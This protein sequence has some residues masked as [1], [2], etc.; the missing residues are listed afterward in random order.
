MFGA[1]LAARQPPPGAVD[2][3]F[4]LRGGPYMVANGGNAGLVNAHLAL[5]EQPGLRV[6]RGQSH[7]VDLVRVNRAGFRAAGWPLPADPAAYF[8]F[9][10]PVYAPCSGRV[11][12]A[13]DG[14]ADRSPPA[15]D[16]AHLA[17]NYVLLGCRG[18][19]VLLGHL[20]QGSVLV[21]RG[22]PVAVGDPLAR[23]GN[24]GN[25]DEPHLHI[26][27]Q[28]PG[29]D[30]HPLAGD[31]VPVRFGGEYLVRNSIITNHDNHDRAL[32]RG[33]GARL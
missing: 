8:I 31:P 14:L 25:T 29:T 23:V 13:R 27:A 33:A 26:H 15:R 28:T 20:R 2:L 24:T 17:G 1:A 11:V 18:L 22:D 30:R 3:V 10:D 12:A 5:L 19:H 9:N 7:G 32:P 6:Y 16:R 4:P 21:K